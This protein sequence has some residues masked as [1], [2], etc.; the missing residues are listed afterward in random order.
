M[1]GRKKNWNPLAHSVLNC[2]YWNITCQKV[3]QC[4]ILYSSKVL[5]VTGYT[6]SEIAPSWSPNATENSVPATTISQLVASRQLVKLVVIVDFPVQR[7]WLR[8]ETSKLFANESSCKNTS[9]TAMI[10]IRWTFQSRHVVFSW[11]TV[12]T[13]CMWNYTLPV[14]P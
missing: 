9:T 10:N 7:K 5:S 12:S 11:N 4:P 6:G 14:Y 2:L 8:I 13:L 3:I 1:Q